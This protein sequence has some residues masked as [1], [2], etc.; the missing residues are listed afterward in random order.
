MNE[1]IKNIRERRSS[2]QFTDKPIDRAT[3]E[4]IV[5]AATWAPTARNTQSYRFTVLTKAD[6]IKRLYTAVGAALGNDAYNFYQPTAFILCSEERDNSN[7]IANVSCAMQNIMLAAYSLGVGNVW[8]NQLKDTS[9]DPGVRAVLTDFGVPADH[10]VYACAALGY[11]ASEPQ[12]NIP[13]K[14]GNVHWV[15]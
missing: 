8:I 10:F 2:R 13:R 1:I 5:E 14:G 11:P 7:G 12:Q 6:D 4:A 9:D 3:L 15:E